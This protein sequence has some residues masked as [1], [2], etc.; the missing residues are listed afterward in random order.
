MH[1]SVKCL[2]VTNGILITSIP[3]RLP[4]KGLSFKRGLYVKTAVPFRMTALVS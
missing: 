3:A 2:F 4:E 1:T